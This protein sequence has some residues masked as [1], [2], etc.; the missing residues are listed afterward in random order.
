MQLEGEGQVVDGPSVHRHG[1]ED[2]AGIQPYARF[3][4]LVAEQHSPQAALPPEVV[5]DQVD[6]LGLL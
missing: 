6:K 2:R 5:Q 4:P 3:Q 1:V